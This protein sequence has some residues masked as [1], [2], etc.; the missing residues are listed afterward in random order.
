MWKYTETFGLIQIYKKDC[1]TLNSGWLQHFLS[2]VKQPTIQLINCKWIVLWICHSIM[3][4]CKGALLLCHV[5]F[6]LLKF[7]MHLIAEHF[8]FKGVKFTFSLIFWDKRVHCDM[9]IYR[10]IQF[11]NSII[12]KVCSNC[13]FWLIAILPGNSE[14][15]Q[16][17]S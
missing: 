14:Q 16:F 8:T 3:Q 13:N 12:K 10:N 5:Q 9:K 11:K 17:S 2:T 15:P 7:S 1:P 6:M 4:L